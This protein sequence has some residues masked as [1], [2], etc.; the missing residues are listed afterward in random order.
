MQ[1]PWRRGGADVV[2]YK[3]SAFVGEDVRAGLGDET[4]LDPV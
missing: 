3:R 4:G 2:R 1:T